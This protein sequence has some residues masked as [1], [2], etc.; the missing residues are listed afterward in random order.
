MTDEQ[1][2]ETAVETVAKDAAGDVKT[3]AEGFWAH[4]ETLT[5]EEISKLKAWVEAHS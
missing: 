1:V 3:T 5:T 2:A 4:L